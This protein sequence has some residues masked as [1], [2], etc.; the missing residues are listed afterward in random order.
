MAFNVIFVSFK[1]ACN[2]KV[3]FYRNSPA[4]PALGTRY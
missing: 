4:R 3:I 1:C 2:Q